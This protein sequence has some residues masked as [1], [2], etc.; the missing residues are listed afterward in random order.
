MLDGFISELPERQ[1]GD[2]LAGRIRMSFGGQAYVLPV[3]SIAANEEWLASLD[4]GTGALVDG[5]MAAGDDTS[6]I[7]AT[8]GAGS[9]AMPAL[10]MSYDETHVLPPWE[11]LKQV[12][13]PHELMLAVFEVW[14]AANPLVDIAIGA[15]LVEMRQRLASVRPS[16]PTSSS[17]PPTAG[18]R[19]KPAAH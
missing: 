1:P 3:R 14:R 13:R 11:E 10:L 6:V 16:E 4:A 18:R 5:L 17:P 2:I 9:E 15:L 12:A 7:I 19:R 8:L